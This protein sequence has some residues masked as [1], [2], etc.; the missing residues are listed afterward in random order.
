VDALGGAIEVVS[1]VGQGTMLHIT[2]PLD[3]A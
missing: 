1:P 3:E 2:L